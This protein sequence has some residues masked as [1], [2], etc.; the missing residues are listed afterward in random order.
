M[1]VGALGWLGL[2]LCV[3]APVLAHQ[4]TWEPLGAFRNLLA[5]GLAAMVSVVLGVLR[6]VQALKRGEPA[7]P[8]PGS[9]DAVRLTAKAK[10]YQNSRLWGKALD[11]YQEVVKQFPGSAEAKAAKEEFAKIEAVLSAK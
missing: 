8:A 4:G 1:L 5:G 6:A 7:A 9:E 3:A 10:S 2:L 11:A